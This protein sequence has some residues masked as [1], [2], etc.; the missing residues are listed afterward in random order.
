VIIVRCPAEA[1]KA[2]TN[3]PRASSLTFEYFFLLR[4]LPS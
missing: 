3:G 2:D 4:G 1:T